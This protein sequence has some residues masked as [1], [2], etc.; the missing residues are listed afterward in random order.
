MV[1]YLH[2]NVSEPCKSTGK[3]VAPYDRAEDD[4]GVQAFNLPSSNPYFTGRDTEIE[5]IRKQLKAHGKAALY[6]LGGIGKTQTVAEYVDR[7]QT[8]YEWIFWVNADESTLA[9]SFGNLAEIA[10]PGITLKLDEQIEA[11]KRWLRIQT[12][13]IL[14]I[15]DNAD[16]PELLKSY[17][18]NNPNVRV[19][20]TS[21]ASVF[22]ALG[23]A[24]PIA[25]EKLDSDQSVEFLFKRTGRSLP[26]GETSKTDQECGAAKKLSKELDGLPLA[27]EQAG[28]FMRELEVSFSDYLTQYEEARLAFLEEQKPVVGN[29]PE[30]VRTT[31]ILNFRAV[32]KSSLASAQVLEL[33]A[34]L[35]ADDIPY[36]LL[37]SGA[38]HLGEPIRLAL[39][40]KSE[41]ETRIALAKLLKPLADYS[42]IRREQEKQCYSIHRLVQEVLRDRLKAAEQQQGMKRLLSWML[43]QNAVKPGQWI[44]RAVEALNLVFPLVEFEDWQLCARLSPHVEEV[45]QRLNQYPLESLSLVRLLYQ[46]GYYLY[47]QK[48]YAKV[49][50][51]YKQALHIAKQHLG[52]D[53]SLVGVILN[54]Q[55]Q[56]YTNQGH[57][58]QAEQLHHQALTIFEQDCSSNYLHLIL[59]A[60][61]NLA[62]LYNYQGRYFE[63]EALHLEL[64][65][66]EKQFFGNTH[67]SVAISLNNLA[68]LYSLQGR[69][70]EAE[71]LFLELIPIQRKHLGNDHPELASSLCSLADTYRV[72]KRFEEAEQTHKEAL[73]IKEQC[74]GRNH[75]DVANSLNNLAELYREQKRDDDAERLHLQAQK[76]WRQYLGGNH[77]TVAKSLNNLALIYQSKERYEDSEKLNLEALS[78]RR[79]LGK[80]HPDIRISLHNLASL[81]IVQGRYGEA[82]PLLCEALALL[83]RHFGAE[84]LDTVECGAMLSYVRHMLKEE[85]WRK[86]QNPAALNELARHYKA[87]RKYGKAEPI[88]LRALE[89]SRQQLGDIHPVVAG[90]FNNLASL[91]RAQK[92]YGDAEFYY[93][94]ALAVCHNFFE[95]D[96]LQHKTILGNFVGFMQDVIQAG[97]TTDLSD[98]PITQEVLRQVISAGLGSY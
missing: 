16:E 90:I 63:A 94:Q 27:L 85:E 35:A 39:A 34:F 65:D 78:I 70:D 14:L 92:C 9:A 5:E 1:S 18:P 23:I 17:L 2:W 42:L 95:E 49:D 36:E 24:N 20:L 88:F 40:D 98:N 6:G 73:E 48:H 7:Y 30:S 3:K 56:L 54:G 12:D 28:A 76:I 15:F 97:H 69:S 25:L 43:P 64:I 13:S 82:E 89:L 75:P 45:Q 58:D 77:P 29:Y 62:L 38:E 22:D 46:F 57:Y 74:F 61:N 31:W 81:Y 8:A 4:R 87:Q 84:H 32:A 71:L 53:H 21:R 68:M 96:P 66:F 26:T 83:K 93:L 19:L 80:D 91:Y 59:M 67:P 86:C 60:K 51:F 52:S 50:I 44:E 41:A 37:T 47:V 72:Q 33:S 55:A 10:Q 11:V 79:Q